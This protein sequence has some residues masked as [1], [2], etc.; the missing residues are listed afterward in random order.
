V[1]E[2]L[3]PPGADELSLTLRATGDLMVHD[4]QNTAA[5]RGEA[6]HN[7]VEVFETL[8][9]LTLP[10]DLMFG[11]LETVLGGDGRPYKG[12]PRFNTPDG[13]AEALKRSGFD[14]L[15]TANN[16]SYD[17][18]EDGLLRTLDVLAGFDLPAVGTFASAEA[19]APPWLIVE[20]GD[21]RI[22][23]LAYTFGTNG[24]AIP[25]ARKHEV[26]M[27]D[28]GK[29]VAEVTALRDLG[30]DAVVVGLHWG[31]EYAHEPKRAQRRIAQKLVAAGADILLG[32]HPHVLQPM[33]LIRSGGKEDHSG[34]AHYSL[35]NF[36][37]NMY[38][39]HTDLG[40]ILE[41]TLAKPRSGGPARLAGV[42]YAPTWVHKY[43]RGGE[44]R[45]FVRDLLDV[46]RLCAEQSPRL[47]AL[48]LDAKACGDA[49]SSLA[50]AASL[51]GTTLRFGGGGPTSPKMAQTQSDQ[52]AQP[53]QQPTGGS[54][55]PPHPLAD[56]MLRV[57]AGLLP[58]QPD[59]RG[60]AI[61]EPWDAPEFGDRS[62]PLPAFAIDT[63]EVSGAAYAEFLAV[64]T[65]AAAPGHSTQPTH[66][67]AWPGRTPPGGL[68]DHPVTLV[69]ASEAR[70]FCA[71]RGARLPNRREWRMAAGGSAGQVFPWGGRWESGRANSFEARWADGA[72][73]DSFERSAPVGSFPAG[74]SPIGA[75]DMSGNVAEWVEPSAAAAAQLLQLGSK[76]YLGQALLAG[77][78]WFD[79]EPSELGSNSIRRAAPH[80][81]SLTAG[82][83]CARDL[84]PEE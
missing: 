37:S 19:A 21:F 72:A 18:G 5:D 16:H 55:A 27:L 24:I 34:L 45:Y 77:G 58:P 12:Y 20:S 6:G 81:R 3:V 62:T 48:H 30:V 65:D 22:G 31:K 54:N 17:Q 8:E 1:I 64:T 33:E 67:F 9:H 44:R 74:R 73:P 29:A 75:L 14:I 49:A 32:G 61:A 7:F 78:S 68:G 47:A 41:V 39:P 42:R 76:S 35:G 80:L 43:G 56:G 26:S 57:V 28:V 23:F 69:N 84:R 63:H 82:F 50:H 2:Q 11:N 51:Y 25:S 40:V 53:E 59:L 83:R 70:A 46:T 38:L 71:W 60:A 4:M 13:F 66:H 10:A 36:I 15:Q 79:R 52:V